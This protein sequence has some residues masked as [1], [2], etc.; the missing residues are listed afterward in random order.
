[1]KRIL[2]LLTISIG[3]YFPNALS[4]DLI[5]VSSE[6][7]LMC[8]SKLDSLPFSDVTDFENANRG[9]IATRTDPVIRN[10]NGSISFDLSTFDFLTEECPPN[11]NCSL[12]RQGQLNR[13]HGLFKVA[14]HIYQVR[15]FDLANMTLVETDNGWLVIDPLTTKSTAKAAMDLVDLH[16]GKRPI[17]AVL[18]T[19]SHIDH[20]GGI[21]GIISQEQIDQD[22]VEVIAPEGFFES[23]VSE[24]VIAGNAM[25]RRA[26]YMYGSFLQAKPDGMIGCGLGQKVSSGEYSIL[27]PTITI[28]ET[29]QKVTIDGLEMIFQNTPGAEA[30][31][32][33]MIYFP[34]LKAFCQAEEINHT[35]HNLY[36]LR[37]AQVRNGL[38]WAKYIDESIQLFGTE[39][40][41]S[42]GSHHWPTWNN[43]S[44][45]EFW[46]KQRD[47]YK[48]I[49]D[50]TLYLANNGYNKEEIA[51]M[52]QLPP[53]LDLYF[54]NRGYYG[55]LSHNAKAQY[56]LYYGWFD[57]NPA[58]LNPLTHTESS[59]HYVAYMGGA[60]AVISKARIDIDNGN[61]RF[62]AT[63]LDHVV[64]A[65]PANQ[66][67]R[68]LLASVYT[69][70]GF[71][72]ESGPW[73]NFYL[74]GAKEL[75]NGIDGVYLQNASKNTS[76]DIISNVPLETFYDFMAV[77]LDRDKSKGKTY[78][79]NLIFPDIDESISL[80]LTNDVLHN[81]PNFLADTPDATITLNK[82]TFNEIITFRSTGK[83]KIMSGE[84]RIEG[85]AQAYADF[86][87]MISTPFSQSFNIIEP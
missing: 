7:I 79:F 85:N 46:S 84:L 47:L 74:T 44:I 40:E 49:H 38:E 43:E 51:E 21:K 87:N 63:V 8:P 64:F 65:D 59:T 17:K 28:S 5:K 3:Y 20:F 68:N 77:R 66:E 34:Q 16:L 39:V 31:A 48:F 36:T 41:V 37:G 29:G 57:G 14:E 45:L 58:N 81:R 26:T 80:Y 9:F 50:E 24:N 76:T 2:I 35:L 12:W 70:L 32:E 60:D 83:E 1:M 22:G 27:A 18:I 30:P 52:I 72:S 54:A 23:A 67:A 78:T 10:E 15:G 55:T 53:S 6:G 61:L 25:M 56:Q 71:D 4:T 75:V 11:T 86:L 69:R 19:H 73:R 13:I 62:A 82:S 33:C 42:F